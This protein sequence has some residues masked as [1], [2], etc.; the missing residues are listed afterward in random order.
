MGLSLRNILVLVA[1]CALAATASAC[2]GDDE[3]RTAED[4]PP[5]AIAL[6]EDSAVPRAEFDELMKRAEAN[7]KAQKRPF[8]KVGTP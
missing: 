2:G 7:Y 6:V 5:D 3:Q 1:V 8:P 4:V